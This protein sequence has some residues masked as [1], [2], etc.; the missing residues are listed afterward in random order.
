MLFAECKWRIRPV[1]LDVL[2]SLENKAKKVKWNIDDRIEYYAVFARRG[3][4]DGLMR[5]ARKEKVM[6]FKGV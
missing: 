3:F 5:A 1:G 2:R 6:L 4:T